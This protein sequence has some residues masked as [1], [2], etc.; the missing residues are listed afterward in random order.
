MKVVKIRERNSSDAVEESMNEDSTG[1]N[2]RSAALRKNVKVKERTKKNESGRGGRRRP[3]HSRKAYVYPLNVLIVT[4]VVELM[5]SEASRINDIVLM[6]RFILGL[7]FL[8]RNDE[9]IPN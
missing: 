4:V 8:Y 5:G 6:N 9:S 1:K 2:A 3:T 7:D